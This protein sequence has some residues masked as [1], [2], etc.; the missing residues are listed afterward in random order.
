[1][2]CGWEEEEGWFVCGSGPALIKASVS[3]FIVA[4]FDGIVEGLEKMAKWLMFQ[5]D[6]AGRR[7]V[8]SRQSVCGFPGIPY[9]LLMR[10]PYSRF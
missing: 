8:V 10:I 2:G 7:Q 6:L 3:T 4:F 9:Y 1:M 5:V